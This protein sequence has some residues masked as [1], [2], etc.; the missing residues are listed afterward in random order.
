MMIKD[1]RAQWLA[2]G[3]RLYPKYGY[4]KL[5]VRLLAAETGMSSGMF[6][7]IFVNKE[8]FVRELLNRQRQHIFTGIVLEGAAFESPIA[9]LRQA[10]YSLAVNIRDHLPWVH[11]VFVDADNRVAVAEDFLQGHLFDI[12]NGF[13]GLL[14]QCCVGTQAQQLQRLGFLCSS[15]MASMILGTRLQDMGVLPDELA[16]HVPEMLSD[17]A[18]EQRIEWAFQAL[19]G[20]EATA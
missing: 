10:A 6:H 18:I 5:S 2:A 15:V 7:H 19:F 17:E 1:I 11:R 8:E 3:L 16:A 9:C 13:L 20:Q 14:N 12:T 4:H